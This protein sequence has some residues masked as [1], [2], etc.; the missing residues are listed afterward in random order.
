MDQ[1]MILLDGK[2]TSEKILAQLKL[3]VLSMTQKP[4]LE[5]VLV[6][7]D[8]ASI[9]YVQM[10]KKAGEGVGITVNTHHLRDDVATEG[11]VEMIRGF[12]EDSEV[13]GILVQLPLPQGIDKDQVLEAISPQK[14]VDGLTLTNQH[15]LE[16]GDPSAIAPAT[17]KGIMELQREYGIGVSGKNVVIVN[18]SNIVGIPLGHLMKAAGANVTI[19]YD[20][21]EKIPEKTREA[22]ILVSGVGQAG[23]I[24]ADMVKDG[25]VVIDVGIDMK[26]G[27]VSGDVDFENVKDKC[28]YITPV[29]GGVGPMTVASLLSSLVSS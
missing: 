14:D 22:D 26:D 11:I 16:Q 9:K 4:R 3:D 6:G 24:T 15:L 27:K 20:Q 17:P 7:N 19:C 23:F 10:K 13:S 25:A 8:P 5:V 12:N 21:T 2:K 1:E 18:N 29:P 28:S